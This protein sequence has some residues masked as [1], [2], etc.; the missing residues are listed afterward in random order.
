MKYRDQ[1]VAVLVDVQ[2]MYHSARNLYGARVNFAEILKTAVSGRKL[3]RA[4][5]YVVRSDTPEEKAFFDALE[6]AGFE[7]KVKDL[8]IFYGGLKKAD[9]DVGLSVDAIRF[10]SFAEALVLVS[11]DGD[12]HPLLE[13]LKNQ[14]RQVE[15]IAFSKTASKSLKDSAD[16]FVD[17][18]ASPQ[19]YMMKIKGSRSSL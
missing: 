16:E 11:G 6:K 8:Q 13:Y 3:V 7:I 19:K 5:A 1:R 14:G 12:F 4:V 18:S 2:N 17:L 10:A 9:W 15:V